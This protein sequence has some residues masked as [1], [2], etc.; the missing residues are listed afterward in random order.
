MVRL[1][2]MVSGRNLGILHDPAE[3][4]RPI[5]FGVSAHS[6]RRKSPAANSRMAS[7]TRFLITPTSSDPSPFPLPTTQARETPL[8]MAG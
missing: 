7:R 1:V 8:A 5:G 6:R 2:S 3:G 4:P